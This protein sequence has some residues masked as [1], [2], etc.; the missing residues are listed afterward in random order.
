MLV[1]EEVMRLQALACDEKEKLESI[2]S[3]ID[4]ANR[5]TAALK[6]LIDTLK[7]E[8]GNE[9]LALVRVR[10]ISDKVTRLLRLPVVS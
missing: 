2:Q 7:K 10:A 6:E 4:K 5:D 1:T 9:D 8:M 3:M